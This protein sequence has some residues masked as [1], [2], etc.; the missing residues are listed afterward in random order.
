MSVMAIKMRLAVLLFCA[1]T[2]AQAGNKK[3]PIS[4]VPRRVRAAIEYF[5]P[6]AQLIQAR[7]SN[8]KEHKQVYDCTYFR[9]IDLGTIKLRA[10]HIVERKVNQGLLLFPTA[11]FTS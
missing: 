10:G 5:A 6:G 9:N 8:D 3:I 1:W 11:P 2:F 7:V 4:A